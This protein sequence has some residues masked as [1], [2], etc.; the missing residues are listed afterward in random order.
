MVPINVNIERTAI[1]GLVIGIIMFHQILKDEQP[2]IRAASSKS[3]GIAR[4]ACL[5]HKNSKTL[6]CK[7]KNNSG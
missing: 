6:N 5:H 4:K 1:V 7:W 2:S 3:A